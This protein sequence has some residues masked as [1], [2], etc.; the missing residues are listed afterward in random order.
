MHIQNRLIRVDSD[1]SST[2]NPEALRLRLEKP[3]NSLLHQYS[4]QSQSKKKENEN[5]N[6]HPNEQ[7]LEKKDSKHVRLNEKL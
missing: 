2:A 1:D 7:L 6:D 5:E 3:R 4:Y